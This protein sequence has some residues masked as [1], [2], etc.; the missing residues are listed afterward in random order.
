MTFHQSTQI[1]V[2]HVI[3]SVFARDHSVT[4][5]GSTNAAALWL[6]VTGD[7]VS[8]GP[9]D[10]KRDAK[11]SAGNGDVGGTRGARRRTSMISSLVPEL[12]W[13]KQTWG[14]LSHDIPRYNWIRNVC[15]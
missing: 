11:R 13:S 6:C 15:S 3:P 2:I 9:T 1:H 14:V 4:S 8:W 10:T 5:S 7:V 12:A